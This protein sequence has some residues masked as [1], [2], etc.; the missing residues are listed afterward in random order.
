MNRR[1]GEKKGR[2]HSSVAGK[3]LRR[4]K[5]KGEYF[6]YPALQIPSLISE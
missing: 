5:V 3:R 2:T 4:G 6:I 1:E